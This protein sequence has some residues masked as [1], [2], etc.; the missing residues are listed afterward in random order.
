MELKH[1]DDGKRGAHFMTE[2]AER[3]AEMTYVRAGERRIIIDHTFVDESLR[4]QDVG[5]KLLDATVEF[6]RIEGY[7]VLATCAFAKAQLER[8]REK[9][10]DVLG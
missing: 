1:E 10:V 9:Y 8:H 4:G 5:H 2:G 3:V 7:K 6:A